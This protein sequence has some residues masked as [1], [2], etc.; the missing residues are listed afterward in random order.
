VTTIFMMGFPDDVRE[1]EVIN[2]VRFSEGMRDC[3]LSFPP[4]KGPRGYARFDSVTNAQLAIDQ[5]HGQPFELGNDSTKLHVELAKNNLKG[6][7]LS[8]DQHPQG[9]N[10]HGGSRLGKRSRFDVAP[11]GQMAMPSDFVQPI[12]YQPP[13]P[14]D[15][16]GLGMGQGMGQWAMPQMGQGLDTVGSMEASQM[17]IM[18]QGLP[19]Q[20]AAAQSMQ[21]FMPPASLYGGGSGSYG[22]GSAATFGGGSGGRG[23]NAP[24]NAP[25]DTLFLFNLG[26]TSSASS[27]EPLFTHLAGFMEFKA[28]IQPG[29]KPMAFIKFQSVEYAQNALPQIDGQPLDGSDGI[30][31]DFAKNSLG[32]GRRS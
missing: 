24:R 15:L 26:P 1:R 4:G 21:Q 11:M 17:G 2:F 18:Q 16:G 27:L 25:G 9:H 28:S 6:G 13:P 23:P 19:Q 5:L 10:S 29:K 8:K 30:R 20:M 32:S 14:Q 31:A 3:S 12:F 22:G 7:F